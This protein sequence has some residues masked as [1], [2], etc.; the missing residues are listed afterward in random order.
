[1]REQL[2][3]YIREELMKAPDYDLQD[4]EELISGGLIDSLELVKLQLFIEE[5]FG[6]LIDDTDMTVDTANSV[7]A[8]IRLIEQAQ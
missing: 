1:M 3:R 5:E 8:I 4:D 6:L 2:R 7:D